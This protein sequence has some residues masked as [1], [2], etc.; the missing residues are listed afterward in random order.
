MIKELQYTIA[1]LFNIFA[2]MCDQFD[3]ILVDMF[4]STVHPS[5]VVFV[6]LEY[7]TQIIKVIKST[8]CCKILL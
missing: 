2:G 6:Y 7:D 5:A 3:G 8:S 4:V 1:C